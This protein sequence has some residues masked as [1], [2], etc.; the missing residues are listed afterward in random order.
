[1]TDLSFRAR[2]FHVLHK[3]SPN[4][5]AA[6]YANYFLA[7]LI[8]SNAVFVA[9]ETLPSI[10]SHFAKEFKAFEAVSTALFTIEYLS[11]LWVCVEQSR[12]ASPVT[13]RLR[14]AIHPLPLLDL[15]VILT[16]WLPID[17]RF[18]RVAR[19][20]RLLKVLK[21]QHFEESFEKIATG[22]K[23]RAALMVVIVTM[24]LLCIYA[25]ASL[26][27]QLE[28]HAQPAV[29]TS[30][31]AT[32]WWAIE[33]LTTI[34]YGDMVPITPIGKFFSGLIAVF[35]IGIFALPTAIVT[36][37]IVEAGV[38]DP[39]PTACKHCGARSDPSTQ[40]VTSLNV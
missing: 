13:G 11:R 27:F 17:L 6:R 21:L 35:G 10:G 9:L 25:S 2:I 23:R 37:V 28:H 36:A 33:T 40:T 34:G 32:F 1:M 38:S 20:V 14:Y 4:N 19:M 3:P 22:L 7:F 30:I 8:A 24:M 29:F 26:V 5:P 18:L 15:V 16:F 31:P 39:L 12:Y